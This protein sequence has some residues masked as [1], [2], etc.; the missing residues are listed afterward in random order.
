MRLKPTNNIFFSITHTETGIAGKYVLDSDGLVKKGYKYIVAG[1]KYLKSGSELKIK[2]A[3][4][5]S[6]GLL[7][8]GAINVM[9]LFLK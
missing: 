4:W 7:A 9:K 5:L 8:L 2:P 1:D 3:G 6:L